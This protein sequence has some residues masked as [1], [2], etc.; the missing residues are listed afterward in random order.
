[1]IP[2]TLALGYPLVVQHSSFM[3]Y[4]PLKDECPVAAA[5]VVCNLRREG[6][7]VHQEK[8]NFPDVA[9]QEL[10]EA[11]R[12]EMTGLSKTGVRSYVREG[13]CAVKYLLVAAV[14]DLRVR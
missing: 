1:M 2:R 13:L 4:L 5:H 12:E 10:L 11:I 14:T 6:F 9:D 8:V 3:R 7:V